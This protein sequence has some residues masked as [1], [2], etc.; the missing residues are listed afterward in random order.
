M[1]MEAPSTK[2]NASFFPSCVLTFAAVM[3]I[4]PGGI[5]AKK[6]MKKPNTRGKK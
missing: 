3:L 5:T 1:I 2:R 4:K 6:A